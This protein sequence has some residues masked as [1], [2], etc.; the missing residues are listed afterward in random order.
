MLKSYWRTNIKNTQLTYNPP[1]EKLVKNN[2]IFTEKLMSPLLITLTDFPL[3]NFRR[4][5]I[6]KLT[7]IKPI[8]CLK[9][10]DIYVYYGLFLAT[11]Y[12]MT[13]FGFT[14]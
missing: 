6:N 12:F 14:M 11:C 7:S 5:T 3:P 1:F 2:H 8:K 13:E 4:I 9:L 10:Y